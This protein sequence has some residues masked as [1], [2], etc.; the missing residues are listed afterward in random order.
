M[1]ANCSGVKCAA[2]GGGVGGED[3]TG[4]DVSDPDSEGGMVSLYSENQ[5]G[6]REAGASLGRCRDVLTSEW[7]EWAV[8]LLRSA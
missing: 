1:A 5:E 7:G 3:G 6:K 2:M 4:D 8:R